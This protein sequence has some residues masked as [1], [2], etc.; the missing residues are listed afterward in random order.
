MASF[1]AMVARLERQ[2][3][4]QP[5]AY[6]MRVVL[7]AALGFALMLVIVLMAG[8]GLALLA[9]LAAILLF[10][11]GAAALIMLLKFGKLLLLAAVPLWVLV[12][13]S[14]NAL[15]LR[16]PAPK[17]DELT[18]AQAPVLFDAIDRMR[19]RL[20]GPRVH[21]VLIVDNVN[22][23]VVQRPLLGLIGF[24]RNYL[25]LGLPLLESVTPDEALAIVAHEYG[26]LAGSHGRFAAFIYRLRVSWGTIQVLADHWQGSFGRLLGNAVRW[27]APYFNAYTFVLARS[28]E[29]AADR[30]AVDVVGA[31]AV[32][33]ALKRTEIATI[34]YSAFLGETLRGI[35]KS[36]IPPA[37]V[38]SR[39]AMEATRMPPAAPHWLDTAL[40]RKGDVGDT[41]PTLR[42]RL[43]A[44]RV[45]AD[46]TGS[47]TRDSG[48]SA[49]HAWLAEMLPRLREG[50]AAR[51]T[52]QISQSWNQQLEKMQAG[53]ER[54][55]L[56][57]AKDERT[58][59]EDIER[60]HLQAV[61]EPEADSREELEAFNA[62]HPDNSQTLYLEAMIRL[63][64]DDPSGIPLLDRAMLLDPEATKPAC[65][66]ARAFY[67]ARDDAVSAKT[68]VERWNERHRFELARL[69]QAQE[70]N[71]DH[72]LETPVVDAE[73]ADVFRA[74]LRGLDRTDIARLYLV[75][76]VLPA[77]PTLPTYVLAV[78][79]TGLTRLL[80][81][82]SA[83]MR[84]L[85][86]MQWPVHLVICALDKQPENYANKVKAVPGSRLLWQLSKVNA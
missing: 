30:A 16:L 64:R 26:H 51:W 62:M 40:D 82:Q 35:A 75:R 12:R 3:L 10:K 1:S 83:L 39:W 61:L 76:R 18:R 68:Y 80:G 50:A 77:A 17:G 21:H 6:V 27:Y 7:L 2:S 66:R 28:N 52:E 24:P 37:D 5:K 43:N 22:A 63:D 81:R 9:A 57:R 48:E 49:A 45:T 65:E 60:L 55:T 14:M 44:L 4:A 33:N 71:V 38:P 56:L 23:A 54:L 70:L 8:A 15:F 58:V 42:E 13:S 36:P 79:T 74:R 67:W 73:A 86:A 19:K 25:L 11:G 47:P 59:L 84:R 41:H 53:R 20:R 78:E 29:Y 85:A 69:E 34:Q 72:P 46:V 31:A 32:A